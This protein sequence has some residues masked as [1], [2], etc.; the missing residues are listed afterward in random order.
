MADA[1]RRAFNSRERTA[2]YLAADGRC[3]ECGA[4]LEPGWHG[5]HIQPY[6]AGGPTDVANGQALCPT[7]NLK[8]GSTVATELREWQ[9][10]AL[11]KFLRR[12][13]DFLCVATPGA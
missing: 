10:E 11:E 12:N 9:A 3:T 2:L 8:K 5:D 1:Q 13:D 6:S 4:D 7:C